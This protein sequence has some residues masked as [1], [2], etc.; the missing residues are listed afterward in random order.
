MESK[1]RK[2]YLLHIP[3]FPNFEQAKR[4]CFLISLLYVNNLLLVYGF[5]SL[6]R[7]CGKWG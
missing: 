1:K 3:G 6:S 5:R 4:C 2:L 7:D